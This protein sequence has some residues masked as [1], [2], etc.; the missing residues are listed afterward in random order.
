MHATGEGTKRYV[1]RFPEFASASFYRPVLGIHVSSLGIGTYLGD[2]DDAADR[3]YTDALIAA[4][5][6]G[7][8]F[9]DCAI[10]YRNQ[11]S[12]RCIGAALRRLRRDEI[13]VCTKAGFLTPGA[14]PGFLQ[15]DDVVGGMHSMSPEFLA[16]QIE[17]SR[18]NLGVDT[19]D[20]FYLHNPET[21]LGFRTREQFAGR[22]RRAFAQ[23]ERLVEQGQIGWYG[24]ATWEGFRKKDAL[25]LPRLAEI[26]TEE[27]GREH[28]FRFIQLPFNLGMVEAFLERPES[29]LKAAARLG[30]AVVASATLLQTRILAN[31]P[32]SVQ[33]LLPGL[34]SDAQ[35][36]IQ[37]TRSTPGISVALVGMGR[38]EH[39]LAN[40]GVASVAPAGREEYSRLYR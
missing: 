26:A 15:P 18:A 3:A 14:V 23:L 13:V 1:E 11:H 25:S 12:E 30:I 2:A 34:A 4:G 7:I 33:A 37:F 9:F 29:V 8:N 16:D 5:E 39:V 32:E 35:R 31:M 19:I 17:R 22:M 27:G 20:V 28:H 38:R 36:A 10:N 21:Q 6:S 24:V 40:L